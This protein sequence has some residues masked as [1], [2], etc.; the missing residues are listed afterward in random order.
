MNAR[1]VGPLFLTLWSAS[2][3]AQG[4]PAATQGTP[5]ATQGTPAAAQGTP[6]AAS[7][8]PARAHICLA[9]A[10]VETASGTADGAMTAVRATFTSYLTGPSLE[11]APLTSRLSSQAR[12]EAKASNCPYLLLTTLKQVH[13]TSGG[14]SSFLSRV[15]GSAVQ[16]GAYA[17]GGTMTSTAGRVAGDAAAGAAGAAASNYGSS[18]RTKDELTLATRL[19]ASD[20]KVLVDMT[21]KR[22]AESDGEDMLTPLV[23]KAA[24]AV[25]AAVA[26]PGK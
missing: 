1:F 8:T 4:T 25:A 11:V 14:G 7:G 26:K 6:A 22:K 3:A 5:A 21:G 12:E 20:G 19:E 16:S 10:S 2:A 18:T 17:A 9:P 24:T 15:A 23:E 13:K